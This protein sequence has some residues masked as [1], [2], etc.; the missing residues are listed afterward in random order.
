MWYIPRLSLVRYD[1]DASAG[2]M[3]S[4]TGNDSK[5]SVR[6]HAR[7]ARSSRPRRSKRAGILLALAALG[8]GAVYP[9]LATPVRQVPAGFVFTPPP[10]NDLLY[11]GFAR[12]AIPAKTRDGREWD[13]VGGSLPDVFAKLK[14]DDRDLIVTPIQANTLAPTWPNQIFG[15]YRIRPDASV[16]VEL[17][18]SN[19]IANHPICSKQIRGIHEEASFERRLAVDC[20]SGAYLELIVE[21]AHGKMGLGFSYE[22]R[23][24]Q[25]FVTRVF[26]ESPAG[27]AGVT[28][29]DEL[30]AIMG[31][32][33]AGLSNGQIRSLINSNGSTGLRV[34]L[35]K[36]DEAEAELTLRDG[37]IYPS[38]DEG[39]P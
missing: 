28:R 16:W 25:V 22:I 33:V 4:K 21:P 27:R 17:W 35:R 26:R 31:D 13:S 20:A 1:E 23:T 29:G 39:S 5:V 38:L 6:F 14:V 2:D 30:M 34:R 7:A 12:A 19:P 18:D 15:N 8:C 10:P 11:L 32:P 36:A 24:D 9:E 3:K 37:P